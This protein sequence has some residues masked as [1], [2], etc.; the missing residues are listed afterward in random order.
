MSLGK[1]IS[2]VL[3]DSSL[4]AGVHLGALSVIDKADVWNMQAIKTVGLPSMVSDA[5]SDTL[6]GYVLPFLTGPEQDPAAKLAV[7][8]YLRPLVSGLSYWAIQTYFQ[9]TDERD[10]LT[11][12]LYQAGSSAAAGYIGAPLK[13]K[14]G[15]YDMSPPKADGSY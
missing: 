3:Y 6:T 13:M 2:E 14:L 12:V 1:S 10:M 15:L 5:V 9:K 11:Q 8:S 4:C 7:Y